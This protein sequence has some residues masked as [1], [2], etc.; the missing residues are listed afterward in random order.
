MK[1]IITVLGHQV[2]LYN[3]TGDKPDIENIKESIEGGDASGYLLWDGYKVA[4]G[5]WKIVDTEASRWKEIAGKLY[6]ALSRCAYV[7][8]ETKIIKTE[9]IQ[10]YE[11][12][13]Q[14]EN[15]QESNK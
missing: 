2:E 15:T 8:D 13:L 6:N 4:I 10:E 5:V 14:K 11:N 9:A 1:Q 7:S 3:E 12:M